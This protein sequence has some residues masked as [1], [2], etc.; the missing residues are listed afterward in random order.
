MSDLVQRYEASTRESRRLHEMALRVAVDGA[1]AQGKL[2]GPH[3]IYTVRAQGSHL[4]D[5]D[6]NEYIDYVL[7]LGPMML[8]HNHPHVTRRLQEQLNTYV[9][10]TTPSPLELQL[11][12]RLVDIIPCAEA[13]RFTTS[14]TEANMLAVRLA[15]A[16]TGREVILRVKNDYVGWADAFAPGMFVPAHEAGGGRAW[17]LGGVPRGVRELTQFF[18]Y[19]DT[20]GFV[21]LVEQVGRHRVAA[22]IMEPS[23]RGVVMPQPGFLETIRSLTRE[24]GA[25]LIF[26]EVVSGFRFGLQGGQGYFGVIPDLATFGKVIS[27]GIPLGAVLG[28]RDIMDCM[29]SRLPPEERV[30]QSGTWC[31]MP[32]ACAAALAVLEVLEQPDT[33][34]HLNRLGDLFAAE[35]GRVIQRHEVP[36]SLLGIGPLREIAFTDAPVVSPAQDDLLKVKPEVIQEVWMSLVVEGSLAL[37][38]GYMPTLRFFISLAHSEADILKTVDSLDRALPRAFGRAK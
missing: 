37:G 19:N 3:P 31:G 22:V 27:G 7:G 29:S 1:Q 8:G 20:Q 13:C 10:N 36:L 21:R 26:D 25:L 23:F 35:V 5:A 2:H 16:Y 4:W 38:K 33:Y 18:D 28:R 24:I 30:Y 6:G 32:L 34:P 15:R 12:Q 17:G 9:L 11:A 14:G